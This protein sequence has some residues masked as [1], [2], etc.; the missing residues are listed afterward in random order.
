MSPRRVRFLAVM[1]VLVGVAVIAGLVSGLRG[2]AT[3]APVAA[4]APAGTVVLIPGYGGSESGLDV[5]AA[6]LRAAGRDTTV[7]HLP[8][9][10]TGD[11][12]D[13]A[14][15]L[16]TLVAA[17][18]ARTHA[19]S[20]DL[21]GYSAGSIVARLYVQDLGGASRVRRV[22][23][24]GAPNHGADLAST[25]SALVPGVC[26]D[27]CAQLEPGSSLLTALNAKALHTA[28]V[29]LR[30][31]NDTTVTPVSSAILAG[32]TNVL[33]QDV[34]SGAIISH[35]NLPTDPLVVGIVVRELSG[36]ATFTPAAGDC[37]S[38]R[39]VGQ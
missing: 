14:S 9:G 34:C 17:T 11:L 3:V 6:Q 31:A 1:A 12:G 28:W 37:A 18:L 7:L 19:A 5:L 36:A 38:L 13:Q 2:A 39:A 33:L 27:A 4:D 20:V 10:G 26:T 24:F 30:T 23:T 21:V 35:G 22:V 8:G 15:A 32:A 29:S 25:A 16:G